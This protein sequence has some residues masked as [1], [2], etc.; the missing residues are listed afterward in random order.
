MNEDIFISYSRKDNDRV[1]PIVRQLR[2]EGY[3]VWLDEG[4]IEAAALWAEQIVEGIKSCRVLLFIISENSINS[5]NV[6]KEVMLASELEK[7]ILPVYL[8]ECRLPDRY[9]YQLTGIQHIELFKEDARSHVERI[10]EALNK[11][12]AP[13]ADEEQELIES[14]PTPPS[15]H[16]FI[17]NKWKFVLSSL[18]GAFIVLWGFSSAWLFSGG[19]LFRIVDATELWGIL[20]ITLGAL[21]FS[22]RSAAFKPWFVS[23]GI[24]V[25]Q[26]EEIIRKYVRICSAAT[27]ILLFAGF[28]ILVI[29]IMSSL[30]DWGGPHEEVLSVILKKMYGALSG[31]VIS[32]F[33]ICA[34]VLPTKFKLE[35][36]LSDRKVFEAQVREKQRHLDKLKQT[37]T[38][39]FKKD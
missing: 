32:V 29:G 24:G 1:I 7:A 38:Q 35:S 26:E 39:Y 18:I 2:E 37:W 31:P 20:F 12:G 33:I 16:K 17:L 5:H 13:K 30:S 14:A 27:H 11:A 23:F 22:Y 19:S 3:S 6:L 4:Q 8:Q 9:L 28:L 34:I 21:F 36:L 25:P 15:G 10:S